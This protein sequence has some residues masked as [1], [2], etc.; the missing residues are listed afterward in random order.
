MKP[1]S[2]I[3]AYLW[4]LVDDGIEE[5][6]RF[7]RHEV[8]LDAV[9]VATA[10]HTF[11]QL[12]PQRVG[13]KLLTSNTAA[14][15]FQP[16]LELYRDT[17]MRPCVAPMARQVNPLARLANSC[18]A[19][20]LELI[21]WTVC[22]HNSYL[23]TNYP[24][25]AVQTAYGDNLG[26]SLCPGVDDV[27]TYL[28]ALCQDL[29]MNYGVARLELESCDFG[30]YGHA[31]YHVKDGVDLGN[32][33]RYLFGLSFSEGCMQKAQE[34]GLDADGLRKWVRGQLDQV[35]AGGAPIEG[36]LDEF[37]SS[38]QDLAAFQ[39]MREELVVSLVR[40][41]KTATGVEIAFMGG[42][43][44]MAAVADLLEILAYTNSPDRVETQVKD[45]LKVLEE[46]GRLVVGLQ[47]YHPCANSSQELAAN[48]KRALELGIRQ[49]SYYNYGIMPRP[50]LQWIKDSITW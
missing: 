12:R 19:E 50:N 4:D 48:V 33:G 29:A 22:M 8:G 42:N 25:C 38:R 39:Q 21:S 23:A 27:R 14:I 46:P 16:D 47:A 13:K 10:Y 2:T 3:W 28:I 36:N 43:R 9:S 30:G 34:R 26:W 15:Y 6:V 17:C 35:F 49:F 24:H 18:A 45:M 32:I 40:Q 5:T 11:Q 41:L 31:H 37:L 44:Q 1:Y 7:L 20:G